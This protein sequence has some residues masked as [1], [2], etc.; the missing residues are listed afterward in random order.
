M[1]IRF[2]SFH[3]LISPNLHFVLSLGKYEVNESLTG[4]LWWDVRW[5]ELQLKE[6]R[7]NII[8]FYK[9][10][11]HNC[12]NKVL[13][14]IIIKVLSNDNNWHVVDTFWQLTVMP[15]KKILAEQILRVQ[16]HINLWYKQLWGNQSFM[17]I[18]IN[19]GILV[20]KI[21]SIIPLNF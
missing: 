6:A 10:N 13:K 19:K 11:K 21:L 18:N 4:L 9:L 12:F 16:C 3:P 7:S 17:Y 14:S 5:L 1:Y 8:S 20:F 15:I 2:L